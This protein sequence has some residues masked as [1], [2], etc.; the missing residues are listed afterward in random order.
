MDKAAV[1]ID[2]AYLDF[3]MRRQLR[4]QVDYARLV[5]ELL[6][7]GTELLRAY[8][9]TAP[10]HLSA[11]PS[12]EDLE[13]RRAFEEFLDAMAGVPRFDVRL[14]A[15]ARRND[16]RGRTRYEQKRVDLLLGLDLVRLAGSGKVAQVHLVA[17]D[18]DFVPAVEVAK[19]QGVLCVLHHTG[20]AHRDLLSA[21]DER[22]RIDSAFIA[23][24]RRS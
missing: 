15:T 20:G 8:Y 23:A 10:P 1:L 13:R 17:G 4:R 11:R 5:Q 2:G 22:R 19:E 3:S 16:A 14:G 24:V 7:P 9:Y 18:S 21:A 12:G 6:P